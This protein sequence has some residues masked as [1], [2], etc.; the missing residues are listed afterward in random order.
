MLSN[1]NTA[2]K[3]ASG[4]I[5]SYAERFLAQFITLF[6]SIILA[7][8]LDPEHYGIIAI[9]TVFISIC[10]ALVT[11]GFGNALVQKKDA[12]D[13]DFNT[14]C[15]VSVCISIILYLVLY[16]L[17]PFIS[18]FYGNEQ[19]TIITRV[20]GIRVI[21]SAYNSIQ[22]AYVQR[23]LIFKKFFFATL[24]G[25]IVSAVLGVSIALL[26]GGVW[27]IVVQYLSNTIIDTCI[28]FLT[29]EW[30]PKFEFSK[31]SFNS[32]WGFGA[33]MLASTIVYTLKDNIRSLIIGKRFSSSDL[34][35]YNQGKKYPQLVVNDIVSSL[36]KVLFPVLSDK[37]SNM[38]E[39]KQVM[40]RSNQLSS[41][42]LSPCII[43]LIAVADVFII[44]ILTEKWLPAAPY[45]RILCLMFLTRSIN[46]VLQK[47][48]LAIGKSEVILFYEIFTTVTTI[49][50][51]LISV[52]IFN[53]IALIAWSYVF[54]EILGTI[55][56]A[57]YVRKFIRYRFR[58][59]LAD[60]CS[61]V[62]MS[63][64]MAVCV[65]AIGRL[66][67]APIILLILQVLLGIGVYI[68]LSILTKN[69]NYKFIVNYIH[70]LAGGRTV[71]R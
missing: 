48:L 5:W 70:T 10:D 34:A 39:M 14:I 64:L 30:K 37:Q 32:M 54:V 21:F 68:G 65:S 3:M 46:T 50:L 16:I 31:H 15:W 28:L 49:V 57:V 27:A 61:P 58:E 60:Y 36:G 6:V 53:S 29:I 11:G 18:H 69:S 38:N 24:G 33:K 1:K 25:T 12:N 13:L 19:L 2:H 51:L 63:L 66:N 8:I 71:K 40:R 9:V 44:S 52:F 45:M 4:L 67:L 17:A 7:R 23:K 43:G 26:G 55:Y 42:I 35:F 47:G 59:M 22:Q 56:Y 20:M 62:I 41:Y